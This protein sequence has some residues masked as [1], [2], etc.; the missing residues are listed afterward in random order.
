MNC[1]NRDE[2]VKDKT[3]YIEEPTLFGMTWPTIAEF[4]HQY[5]L[6]MGKMPPT[7]DSVKEIFKKIPLT[8]TISVRQ[9]GEWPC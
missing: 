6:R 5:Q 1:A 3:R 4:L 2:C 8:P 7:P 9:K